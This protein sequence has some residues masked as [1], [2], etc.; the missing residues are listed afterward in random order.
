VHAVMPAMR[1]RRQGLIVNISRWVAL[2]GLP[3]QG[4][5]ASSKFALEGLTESLRMETRPFGIGATLIEP[6]DFSTLITDNRVLAAGRDPVTAYAES[7]AKAL[8][9]RAEG[10]ARREVRRFHS[11]TRPQNYGKAF[12]RSALFGRPFQPKTC[13]NRKAVFAIKNVRVQSCCPTILNMARNL[14]RFFYACTD[15]HCGHTTDA[16]CDRAVGA[17]SCVRIRPFPGSLRFPAYSAL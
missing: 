1:A 15:S 14:P 3:F 11:A 10:R 9:H 8:C 5:Y 16:G 17:A 4:L 6:G 12:S 2:F 7:F 13:R